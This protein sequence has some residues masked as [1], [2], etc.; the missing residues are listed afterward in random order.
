MVAGAVLC[1]RGGFA[2]P[3]LLRIRDTTYLSS[4]AA[5][6]AAERCGARERAWHLDL[7]EF[8]PKLE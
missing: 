2:D 7:T 8:V 6:D 4:I 1:G 5:L 3:D